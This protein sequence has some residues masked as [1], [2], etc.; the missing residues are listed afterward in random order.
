MV[1]ERFYNEELAQASFMVGS[2]GEAI[3]VDPNR[4][5]DQY[6]DAAAAA[7]LRIVA[8]TETHIHADY[9]SGAK[10]LAER[11]GATLYLSDEGGPDWR[12]A[13]QSD[14]NVRTL[15]HGDVIRAGSVVLEAVH[16]PGHTPEHMTFLLTDEATSATP[17]GAFTGDFVFVGDVGRPDLLEKAAKI[18]GTMEASARAL[19]GSITAFRDQPAHL[20]IWP[21]HGAG[22]A[23]G[24]ALG[25]VPVSTLGYERVSNWAFQARGEAE[26]V[27]D[28]LEGQPEPP[29]YFAQMKQLNRLGPPP[30][31]NRVVPARI[32]GAQALDLVSRGAFV[33]DLR[34][35]G[36]VAQGFI[37]GMVNLPLGK[38][39]VQWVGAFAPYDQPI[40]L[41]AQSAEG[42]RHAADL[43]L[44]IGLD[45]VPGWFGAD[46]MRAY[47][48]VHG[49]LA[50]I[51]NI[52]P[53]DV[54]CERGQ[55]VLDVRGAA[56]ASQG[57]IP[58]ALHI[59][60]GALGERASEVAGPVIVH[61]QGGARASI[62]ATLLVRHGVQPVNVMAAGFADYAA[63][64]LPIESRDPVA[65]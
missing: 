31:G 6:V 42:A 14:P 27:H 44:L 50:V 4:W 46:A 10:E 12:Y 21:G 41:L 59:P 56:E 33:I 2:A 65:H 23:C 32:P 24:K 17:L 25:S 53:A 38:P 18:T 30:T 52:A 39:L 29:K 5:I 34:P 28:V 36:E 15:K 19:Y 1:L 22:S 20:L 62:G 55:C 13:F 16:T 49:S 51:P 54:S 63:L 37:P 60:L 57:G 48:K 64:G 40:Y 43:L 26:F 45:N 11:V 3:I 47:E 58:G 61:C 7:G 8:V 35:P 9:L